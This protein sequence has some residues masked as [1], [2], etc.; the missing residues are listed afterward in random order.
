MLETIHSENKRFDELDNE[1]EDEPNIF[2]DAFHSPNIESTSLFR[3]NVVV[4]SQTPNLKASTTASATATA[5][6]AMSMSIET[7]TIDN[8]NSLNPFLVPS[9]ITKFGESFRLARSTIDLSPN[10]DFSKQ[11]HK[12]VIEFHTSTQSNKTVSS[13]KS[14]EDV[15]DRN[16]MHRI[17]DSVHENNFMKSKS[18]QQKIQKIFNSDKYNPFSSIQY[19]VD[20]P[21]RSLVSRFNIKQLIFP[22]LFMLML[23]GCLVI[24]QTQ[25]IA[26]SNQTSMD[27][28][29]KVCAQLNQLIQVEL[30]V[31]GM[32]TAGIS[33]FSPQSENTV[34]ESIFDFNTASS[35]FA[36]S[37]RDVRINVLLPYGKIKSIFPYTPDLK[38][39]IDF[40]VFSESTN[41][42]YDCIRNGNQ[43]QF[44]MGWQ[45]PSNESIYVQTTMLPLYV[46]L[47][48]SLPEDADIP[49][50]Y[51]QCIEQSRCI[52]YNSTLP[53]ILCN[54]AHHC[55]IFK[56]DIKLWGFVGVIIPFT[57]EF[58]YN[59]TKPASDNGIKFAIFGKAM[60]NTYNNIYSNIDEIK[61]ANSY[62]CFTGL[63][64]D[65][66]F[67]LRN[68]KSFGFGYVPIITLQAVYTVVIPILIYIL[69]REKNRFY[70][71]LEEFI[72]S[73]LIKH[74]MR[75]KVIREHHEGVSI[76]F[77]DIVG[78]TNMSSELDPNLMINLL[79]ELFKA[80]DNLVDRHGVHKTDIIGDAFMC[81]TGCPNKDHPV[82]S[83]RRIAHF[84]F[85]M[86]EATKEV[87]QL[88]GQN[89]QIRVGCN[90]GDVFGCIMGNKVPHYYP[91]G[92]AVNIASR[93]ES[94]SEPGRICLSEETAKLIDG[95]HEFRLVARDPI[96]VKGKGLMKTY[97]L[98]MNHDSNKPARSITATATATATA[99][100]SMSQENS[101]RA[102]VYPERR[103]IDKFSLSAQTPKT[104]RESNQSIEF[105]TRNPSRLCKAQSAQFIPIPIHLN[106]PIE[107]AEKV[108]NLTND[109]FMHGSR[110]DRSK[111]IF[112]K[113]S[114]RI[115]E[116]K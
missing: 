91:F 82:K 16:S 110:T 56:G 32:I 44:M 84:A 102:Y 66:L 94:N 95:L 59:I 108:T 1:N 40:N 43:F 60:D 62:N 99:T 3:S 114:N 79:N 7:S 65:L 20:K 111:Q 49:I 36:S 37:I 88:V 34:Q 4:P 2:H 53:I 29:E 81:M 46:N 11:S 24:Y 42:V 112:S 77:S 113:F 48:T 72:P 61:D 22:L 9:L 45:E 70:C 71:F 89:I 5:T 12:S 19:A 101:S 58:I 85:D 104:V 52:I 10:S 26:S 30:D 25:A 116:K 33:A 69:I 55:I 105:S 107:K 75:G 21:M 78:Y 57:K 115:F 80:Y 73:H 28:V 100:T 15:K 103:F 109:L 8:H 54:D 18:M 92:D 41:E 6:K 35:Y 39:V 23:G 86:L 90:S 106:S 17:Q 68:Q 14:N 87:S 38:Y 98:E 47:N 96:F 67:V 51:S 97:F 27:T 93:M 83:A 13:H 63:H 76:L 64:N 31:S 74:V 50:E